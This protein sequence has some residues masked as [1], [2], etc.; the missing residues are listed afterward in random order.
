MGACGNR[1][2]A[3]VII[4]GAKAP[5]GPLAKSRSDFVVRVRREHAISGCPKNR[6]RRG[7]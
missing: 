6:R 2:E 7:A 5:A 3:R 4:A 1:P